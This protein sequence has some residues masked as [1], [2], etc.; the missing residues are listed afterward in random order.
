MRVFERRRLL[1]QAHCERSSIEPTIRTFGLTKL[2]GSSTDIPTLMAD[3]LC[4][5]LIRGWRTGCLPTVVRRTLGLNETAALIAAHS[6]DK[7]GRFPD[8]DEQAATKVKILELDGDARRRGTRHAGTEIGSDL[9]SFLQNLVAETLK[10]ASSLG[11]PEQVAGVI[12]TLDSVLSDQARGDD[13]TSEFDSLATV[14]SIRLSGRASKLA[15]GI[16]DWILGTDG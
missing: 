10:T 1:E 6:K 16:V 13:D 8:L 11:E 4:Q 3:L 9:E 5:D 15:S 14:L 2:G 7:V 12:Q